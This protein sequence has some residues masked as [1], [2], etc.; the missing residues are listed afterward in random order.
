MVE[1]LNVVNC[2]LNGKFKSGKKCR[3]F[4]EELFYG[5]SVMGR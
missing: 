4:L 5:E 2:T 1:A 3:L